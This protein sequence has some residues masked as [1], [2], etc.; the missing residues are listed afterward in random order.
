MS[1]IARSLNMRGNA[2]AVAEIAG[3]LR[4]HPALIWEM[5]K[6]EL[7]DRYS[8]NALGLA[9]AVGAPLAIFAANVLAFLF[10]FRIRLNP[11]DT[12]GSYAAFVLSG[13]AVWVAIGEVM[14]RAP[15]AVLQSANLVKQIVFPSE[16]LPLKIV[17]AGLPTLALCCGVVVALSVA[18]GHATPFGMFVL[19]PICVVY[20]VVMMTGLTYV[21]AGIGVFLRD[22]KDVVALLLSIGL[23]L[24][25]ILYAPASVPAWLERGFNFSPFSHLI[26]CFRDALFE[27]RIVHYA[28]WIICPVLAIIFL[29]LGWRVFRSL[30]PTFGN[31]L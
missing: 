27:G 1:V 4:Q 16:I 26:W 31:A 22:I 18:V 3:M 29:V 24:H 28:S 20:F 19:L 10:I 6:R 8:G 17:I 21:L 13:M 30:R 15:T 9:W 25:P 2:L 23:F 7:K 5:A 12:G 14:G 11:E